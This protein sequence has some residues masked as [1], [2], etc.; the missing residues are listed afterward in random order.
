MKYQAGMQTILD[1]TLVGGPFA[2]G[3][4]SPTLHWYFVDSDPGVKVDTQVRPDMLAAIAPAHTS[5]LPI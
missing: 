4:H 5:F 3:Y 2:I 1:V